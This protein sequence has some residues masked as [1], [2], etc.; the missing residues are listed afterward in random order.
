MARPIG[1]KFEGWRA[2]SRGG[3]LGEREGRR[4]SSPSDR[5]LGE[6]FNYSRSTPKHPRQYTCYYELL[7][8]EHFLMYVGTCS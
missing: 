5:G 2:E 3:V 4:A 8:I 6:R 7:F 1:P